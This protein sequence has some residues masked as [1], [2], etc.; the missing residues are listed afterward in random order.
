V[1]HGLAAIRSLDWFRIEEDSSRTEVF[2]SDVKD[3]DFGYYTIMNTDQN[4]AGEYEC[5]VV[6]NQ[7]PM[8]FTFTFVTIGKFNIIAT[9]VYLN[10]LL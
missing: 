6:S 2:S 5:K 8:T 10:C 3:S 4:S 7:P 9:G 1:F